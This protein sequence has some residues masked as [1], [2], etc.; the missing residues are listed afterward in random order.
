MR[1]GIPQFGRIA[2]GTDWANENTP[3]VLESDPYDNTGYWKL[4]TYG[5]ICLPVSQLPLEIDGILQVFGAAG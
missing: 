5:C 3:T 4:V 2:P 1:D